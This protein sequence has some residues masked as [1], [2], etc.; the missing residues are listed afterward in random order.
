MSQ[1][2][3][4]LTKV[5]PKI[6]KLDELIGKADGANPFEIL[7]PPEQSYTYFLEW[8]LSPN[9]SHGLKELPLKML[10]SSRKE[11][12]KKLKGIDLQNITVEAE[13][14]LEHEQSDKRRPDVI[15]KSKDNKNFLMCIENKTDSKESEDQTPKYYRAIKE[16][17][18]KKFIL[19]FLTPNGDKPQCDEF[20]PLSYSNLVG[21]IEKIKV[22]N[23]EARNLINY[24]CNKWRYE[25][26]DKISD[27]VE[28]LKKEY[29]GAMTAIYRRDSEGKLQALELFLKSELKNIIKNLNVEKYN[30]RG[31]PGR[32]IV[33]KNHKYGE[34]GV[35]IW[36]GKDVKWHIYA[37]VSNEKKKKDFTKYCESK[38]HIG[39]SG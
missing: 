38:K 35:W 9:G 5:E 18:Y 11:W 34:S 16:R 27:I 22:K 32:R 4:Q 12:E 26:D 39:R 19:I 7:K 23:K 15:C 10:A 14:F 21:M 8:F 6:K 30:A 37:S 36:L 24:F 31:T 1:I 33:W 20:K 29:P 17:G 28:A 2:I 25:M 3:T 13:T